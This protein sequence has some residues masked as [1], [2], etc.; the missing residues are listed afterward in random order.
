M[1]HGKTTRRVRT[2]GSLYS[3]SQD[4][5]EVGSL[6]LLVR[7][8]LCGLNP[9]CDPFTTK[10][11][12]PVYFADS[13]GNW[14]MDPC[15]WP[16]FPAGHVL[17]LQLLA[18]AL[19]TMSQL[20]LPTVLFFFFF[21]YPLFLFHN[22]T[23][24]SLSQRTLESPAALTNQKTND[25]SLWFCF[26]N[27]PSYWLSFLKPLPYSSHLKRESSVH[28]EGYILWF[29]NHIRRKLSLITSES[30][31]ELWFTMV[32]WKQCAILETG[33]SRFRGMAGGR[34]EFR[35]QKYLRCW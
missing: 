8:P 25:V 23:C 13:K 34:D 2:L 17:W 35:T 26:P 30:P 19:L 4:P 11:V 10:L 24:W 29:E 16:C 6:T 1:A 15:L 22:P 5:S 21:Y 18:R 20:K 33:G 14:G 12:L 27:N 3:R 7:R 9:D 32:T 31:E 28:A